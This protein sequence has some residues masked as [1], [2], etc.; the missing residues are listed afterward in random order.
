MQMK[1]SR[2]KSKNDIKLQKAFEAER[3][4]WLKQHPGRTAKQFTGDVIVQWRIA[5]YR[6][7]DRAMRRAWLRDNPGERPLPEHLCSLDRPYPG[8]KRY[9]AKALR[10]LEQYEKRMNAT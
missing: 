6:K 8:F 7:A 1:K 10:W 4:L 9:C 3:K 5:H 2:H